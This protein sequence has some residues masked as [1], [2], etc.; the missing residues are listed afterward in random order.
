MKLKSAAARCGKGSWSWAS[1]KFPA[2]G[3]SSKKSRRKAANERLMS[4]S[5]ITFPVYP[6]PDPEFDRMSEAEI[7]KFIT[8]NDEKITFGRDH[9]A[10]ELFII[11]LGD[12]RNRAIAELHR[13]NGTRPLDAGPYAIE[14]GRIVRYKET[15][16][17]P[18]VEPLCN[19]NATVTEEIIL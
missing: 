18:I 13:R 7:R 5:G 15:K 4:E 8:E 3:G 11:G 10:E 2:A 6:P 9:G 14:R 17:G 1:S 19:F 16:E 12:Q